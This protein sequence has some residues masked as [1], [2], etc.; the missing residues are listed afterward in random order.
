MHFPHLLRENIKTTPPKKSTVS[1]APGFAPLKKNYQRW[2][3]LSV[4]CDSVPDEIQA[5][6]LRETDDRWFCTAIH[7]IYKYM[8]ECS[9]GVKN[10]PPYH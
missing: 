7:V 8:P 6:S 2:A 5:E 4:S 1:I 9:R 3:E 10:M